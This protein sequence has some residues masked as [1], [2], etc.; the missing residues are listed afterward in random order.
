VNWEALI[1]DYGYLAVLVGTFFEGETILVLGGIA[2]RYG[3]LK[4]PLVMLAAFLG[5]LIG[6]QLWFFVGRRWGRGWLNRSPTW[7]RRARLV[8][9]LLW[10]HQTLFILSF[11][12]LYGLRTVSPFAIGMAPV[13]FGYF[14]FLNVIGAVVWAV[15]VALLGYFLGHAV[16]AVA[17]EYKMEVLA[18]LVAIGLSIWLWRRIVGRRAAQREAAAL[19]VPSSPCMPTA[20][21]RSISADEA[22]AVMPISGVV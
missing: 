14:V 2:A 18:I 10:K 9:A 12:F 8:R 16:E 20:W 21:A 7:R 3:H 11:R 19:A 17:A 4:L 22:A 13:R 5:S 1:H 15:A 6:D